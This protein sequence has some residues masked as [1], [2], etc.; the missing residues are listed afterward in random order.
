MSFTKCMRSKEDVT[1]T[2]VGNEMADGGIENIEV[3]SIRWVGDRRNAPSP[4]M[5]AYIAQTVYRAAYKQTR[6]KI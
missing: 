5:Q 4:V 3:P 1:M 2:H 6:S